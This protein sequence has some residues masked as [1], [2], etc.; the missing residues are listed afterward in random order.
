MTPVQERAEYINN[1]A[2]KAEEMPDG[3]TSPEQGLFLKLRYMYLLYKDRQ[4][5]VEQGKREKSKIIKAYESDLFNYNC[6]MET[7]N[8]RNRLS[9]LLSEAYKTGCPMCRKIVE[10][11]DNLKARDNT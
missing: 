5:T 6:G 11:F 2:F 10:C 4:I 3:L 8:M 1:L 9:T 7:A